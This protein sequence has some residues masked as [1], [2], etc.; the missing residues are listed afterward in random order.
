MQQT[1]TNNLSQQ[2]VKTTCQ[3]NL[4]QQP[5]SSILSTKSDLLTK[6][7]HQDNSH[8]CASTKHN[9]QLI[10][11]TINIMHQDNNSIDMITETQSQEYMSIFLGNPRRKTQKKLPLYR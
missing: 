11:I 2:P 10:I 4:S 8:I 7:N 1:C 9:T 5:I 3:N 6:I